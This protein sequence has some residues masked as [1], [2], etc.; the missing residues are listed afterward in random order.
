MTRDL[1]KQ[2]LLLWCTGFIL[3]YL[4]AK[5]AGPRSFGR[6]WFMTQSCLCP[7]PDAAEHRWSHF[8]H[9]LWTQTRI[10]QIPWLLIF[11]NQ[12]KSEGSTSKEK[13]DNLL[14]V[15]ADSALT[16]VLIHT[17]HAWISPWFNWA[18]AFWSFENDFWVWRTLTATDAAILILST[19]SI[20]VWADKV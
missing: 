17:W 16:V 15:F 10:L 1:E 18:Q 7:R 20:F 3:Q 13:F 4:L 2:R 11:N 12:E 9:T 19:Q 14:F 5:H 8:A 6:S